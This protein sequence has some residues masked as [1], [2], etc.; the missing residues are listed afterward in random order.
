MSKAGR[1]L[2]SASFGGTLQVEGLAQ[3]QRDLNRVNKT[4]KGEVR[5]GL[6]G[7]GKIVSDQAQL[8]AAAKGLNKTG[9]LIRRIV[10]TVRQQGVFVEAKAKRKS[11]KYPSG[12]PYPAVYEY[13]IRRGRPFLEP[14]LN[15]S[16]NEVERAMERWLDTF[17]SKNDL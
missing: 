5:D 2:R 17:L 4:A 6:K 7:V 13:G 9:Q 15:K 12:Y 11:P 3:L 14:A 8:I 10:P 16:Q 1:A